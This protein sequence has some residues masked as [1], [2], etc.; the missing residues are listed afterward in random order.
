MAEKKV[1]GGLSWVKGEIGATLRPVRDLAILYG[2]ANGPSDAT[3]ALAALEQVRGVLLALDLAVAAHLVDEIQQLTRHLAKGQSHQASEASASLTQ[4]LLQLSEHLD[5]L[6][7]GRDLSPLALWPI[8]N[9]LRTARGDVPLTQTELLA[10]AAFPNTVELQRH[11][12]QLGSFLQAL[13]HGRAQYHRL[14]LDWYRRAPEGQASEHLAELFG[15]LATLFRENVIGDVFALARHFAS[16]LQQQRLPVTPGA[17]SLMGRL[18]WILKPLAQ[19]PPQWPQGNV[20]ALIDLLLHALTPLDPA[21]ES[22]RALRARYVAPTSASGPSALLVERAR[23]LLGDFSELENTLDAF[24]RGAREDRTPLEDMESRLRHA[25]DQL[26]LNDGA[27]L[28]ARLRRLIGELGTLGLVDGDDLRIESAATELLAI[29]AHLQALVEH[30]APADGEG[31][32]P[33]IDLGEL[34]AA[35]LREAGYELVSVREAIGRYHADRASPEALESVPSALLNVAGALLMLNDEGGADLATLASTLVRERYLEQRLVPGE[36]EF[37]QLA[38]A[39]AAL[40]LHISQRQE[41]LSFGLDLL[42]QARAALEQLGMGARP[43]EQEPSPLPP[44]Q[45]TPGS[46][47]HLELIEPA[48]VAP[49]ASED[50]SD[51]EF[52]ELEIPADAASESSMHDRRE[53]ATP[54]LE[55]PPLELSELDTGRTAETSATPSPEAPAEPTATAEPDALELPPL[56]LSELDTGRTAETS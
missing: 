51:W 15:H 4:G 49:K 54:S 2:A 33:G 26:N 11:P 43:P 24:A 12:E 30:R 1:I 32:L 40:E 47:L 6:D 19:Q 31:A 13:H 8:I 5:Q 17:R 14:L 22:L 35:T 25:M 37:D 7:Q 39:V 42:G 23:D 45:M 20:F 41:G 48:P 9:D 27:D 56:E 38:N 52:S 53:H 50:E 21:P 29:K 44:S 3:E 55:L 34:T 28:V 18:D 36:D 10:I 16:A 46:E